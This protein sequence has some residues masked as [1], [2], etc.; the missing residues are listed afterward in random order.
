MVT[1][2]LVSKKPDLVLVDI[3]ANKRSISHLEIVNHLLSIHFLPFDYLSYFSSDQ[4]FRQAWQAY[5]YKETVLDGHFA[6]YQRKV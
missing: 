3:H 6:V 2:D 5:Q 1:E 4:A